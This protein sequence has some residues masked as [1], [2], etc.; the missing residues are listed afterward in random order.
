MQHLEWVARERLSRFKAQ[1]DVIARSEFLPKSTENA[2]AAIRGEVD[3]LETVLT[4]VSL[5]DEKS[6]L[7]EHIVSINQKVYTFTNYLGILLRST[8]LRNPFEAYFAFEEMSRRLLGEP[9]RL[10]LSS[11]WDAAPF[12]IPNPPA[13]LDGYVFIGM[14]AFAS[15][16]ALLLPLAAHEMG[17]A[18]WRTKAFDGPLI[19][20]AEQYLHQEF[21]RDEVRRQFGLEET[22]FVTEEKDRLV[23]ECLKIVGAQAQE[24]FC[25]LFGAALFRESYLFAFDFFISPGFGS[26]EFNYPRLV[27]RV[28]FM[29]QIVTTSEPDIL[30]E[31][32]LSATPSC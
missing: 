23:S 29:K 8:N 15:R 26:R 1:L 30:D 12:Y 28:R 3:R 7:R 18:V 11:E 21:E 9:D 4:E 5:F 16:N 24:A 20:T 31:A 17:H 27:D 2:L 6:Y 32:T 10:I 25:D 22:L 19:T 14:P 13:V